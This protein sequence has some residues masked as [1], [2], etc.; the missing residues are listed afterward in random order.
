M[1]D[2]GKTI[3]WITLALFL[4]AGY[5]MGQAVGMEKTELKCNTFIL[6]NYPPSVNEPDFKFI[7]QNVTL[8][9]IGGRT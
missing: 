2:D 7:N 3:L 5:F 9:K 6:E 4:L 1:I 8:L